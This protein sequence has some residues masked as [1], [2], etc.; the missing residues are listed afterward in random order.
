LQG[1]IGADVQ[2]LVEWVALVEV[3]AVQMGL[4]ASQ[5]SWSNRWWGGREAE[6]IQYSGHNG[7]CGD[8][9]CVLLGLKL[10]PGKAHTANGAV[11]FILPLLDRLEQK[12]AQVVSIRFDAGFIH[13][14]RLSATQHHGG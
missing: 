7:G 5:S 6:V 12:I 9:C 10:R 11:S 2:G 8:Q 4:M 3:V 14:S 13:A 1:V